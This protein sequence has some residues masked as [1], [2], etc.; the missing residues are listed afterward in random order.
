MEVTDSLLQDLK[1][2]NYDI[3]VN[4]ELININGLEL[5]EFGYADLND[6]F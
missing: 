2:A 1:K 5:V 6:E 4:H 3:K